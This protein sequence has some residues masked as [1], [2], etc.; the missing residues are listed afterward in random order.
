MRSLWSQFEEAWRDTLVHKAE[1]SAFEELTSLYGLPRPRAEIPEANWRGVLSALAYGRRGTFQDTYVALQKAFS[2]LNE[3]LE[4]WVVI[5]QN[6]GVTLSGPTWEARH[7]NR[8]VSVGGRLFFTKAIFETVKMELVPISTQYWEG[9]L[10]P[11]N[12]ETNKLTEV[13]YF[14]V[15]PFVVHERTPGRVI[16]FDAEGDPAGSDEFSK[17]ETCLVELIMFVDQENLIPKTWLQDPDY[18]VEADVFTADGVPYG[19]QALTSEIE[20]GDPS[21][22]GPHPLYAYDNLVYSLTGRI[23]STS[24]AASVELRIIRNPPDLIP[25]PRRSV[26]FLPPLT[27]T[28]QPIP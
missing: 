9:S 11:N 7:V 16:D 3:R 18:A 26:N 8:L 21:G 15:L 27:G 17:G 2:F 23:L 5:S 25:R 13:S 24:L 14:E 20:I 12:E 19:G 22:A 10:V 1:G 28:P 6:L 4:G